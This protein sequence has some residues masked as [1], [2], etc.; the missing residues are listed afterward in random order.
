MAQTTSFYWVAVVARRYSTQHTS[1]R[2]CDWFMCMTS[3]YMVSATT[4]FKD[5]QERECMCVLG[6]VAYS[7]PYIFL[8]YFGT[9]FHSYFSPWTTCIPSKGLYLY[10]ISQNENSRISFHV[11]SKIRTHNRSAQTVQINILCQVA[12]FIGRK[13]NVLIFKYFIRYGSNLGKTVQLN[14]ARNSGDHL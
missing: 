8:S 13:Q 2:F 12:T 3:L 10:S 7:E 14:I 5:L 1:L 6:G 11:S 9:S 4:K